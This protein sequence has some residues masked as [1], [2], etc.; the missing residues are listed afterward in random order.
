MIITDPVKYVGNGVG[1]SSQRNLFA[2]RYL[3]KLEPWSNDHA[4]RPEP[5]QFG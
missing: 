1:M 5:Y 2:I 3:T 4:E